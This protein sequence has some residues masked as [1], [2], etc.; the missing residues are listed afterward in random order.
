MI[1]ADGTEAPYDRL[2]LATGSNPFILPVPGQDLAG[3]MTYRDIDDTNA[4]IEAAATSSAPWSSA[5]ACSG[6]K[7]PTA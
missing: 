5:A 1:A 7:R 2:L 6:W 4:M 3:V